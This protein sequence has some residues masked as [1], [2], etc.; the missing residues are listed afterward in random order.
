[1]Y[2]FAWTKKKNTLLY[3]QDAAGD[4][5]WHVYAVTLPTGEAKDLTP[6]K[7]VNAQL[8]GASLRHP[9]EVLIGMNDRDPKYHDLYAVR[10]DTGARKLVMQNDK[11][12]AGFVTDD[13]FQVRLAV[14]SQPD[15]S[16]TYFAAGPKR[17]FDAVYMTVPFD[18]ALTT[19]PA[20]FDDTGRTLYLLDSR[21]RDTA[22]LFAIDFAGKKP[23]LLA[24]GPR[25]R[26]S[27]ASCPIRA[28]TGRSPPSRATSG[29]ATSSSTSA[30][31]PTRTT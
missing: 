20:G 27:R 24:R 5:N 26:T 25:A 15:G 18:D 21:E 16:S 19:Q 17:A 29:S 22:G 13:D 7:G 12:F 30:C 28:R 11:G 8:E 4:E 1:M 3:M 14:Q 31:S 23:T 2:R 10:L 6:Y 9:G